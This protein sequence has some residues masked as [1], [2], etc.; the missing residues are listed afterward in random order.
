MTVHQLKCMKPFFQDVATGVK[1]FEV[2]NNDRNY[3]LGDMLE[4]V[5]TLPPAG[6]PFVTG[7][8]YH[9]KPI[10]YILY[11]GEQEWLGIKPGYV[12][13][14]LE[15][16]QR[17]MFKDLLMAYRRKIQ[18]LENGLPSTAFNEVIQRLESQ[19]GIAPSILRGQ[20]G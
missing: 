15:T 20:G 18:R 16:D 14:G 11:G 7:A 10:S 12:V 19:L 13:L 8:R 5:E 2:R 17:N 9:T 6:S 4:L 1:S 3:Q